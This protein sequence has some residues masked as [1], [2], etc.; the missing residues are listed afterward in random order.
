MESVRIEIL[1]AITA[2]KGALEEGTQTYSYVIVFGDFSVLVDVRDELLIDALR[3]FPSPRHLILT[4]RHI[5]KHEAAIERAFGLKV[6]LHP[7]DARAPRRGPAENTPPAAAYHDP[8]TGDLADL[9]FQF[10]NLPGHT[11]GCTFALLDVHGGTLFTGDAVIGTKPTE[12]AGLD[13]PPDW[14]CDDP[15]RARESILTIA[16]PPHQNI[17][18]SHGEPVV[19]AGAGVNRAAELWAGLR[20]R[21]AA[22]PRGAA[23]SSSPEGSGA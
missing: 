2:F 9:G 3:G 18:P 19:G 7:Q 1:P 4:H 8:F 17:L 5:R 12:P 13:L 6:W 20:A 10:F 11:P 16:L 22:S 21:L 15:V 14:T 23:S